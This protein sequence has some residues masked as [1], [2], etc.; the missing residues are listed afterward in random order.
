MVFLVSGSFI[1]GACSKASETGRIDLELSLPLGMWADLQG[2]IGR[3]EVW[4]DEGGLTSP[5]VAPTPIVT[6]VIDG[7]TVTAQVADL[8]GDGKNEIRIAYESNPFINDVR[9]VLPITA[10]RTF[11]AGSFFFRGAIYEKNTGVLL[12]TAKADFNDSGYSIAFVGQQS[13]Y[14]RFE[15]EP[16]LVCPDSLSADGG[17]TTQGPAYAQVQLNLMLPVA[18]DTTI[19]PSVQ[20]TLGPIELSVHGVD[21]GKITGVSNSGNSGWTSGTHSPDGGLFSRLVSN[22]DSDPENEVIFRVLTNPFVTQTE[23]GFAIAGTAA[24]APLSIIAILY[25]NDGGTGVSSTSVS[26]DSLGRPIQFGTADASV[27]IAFTCTSKEV[28]GGTDGGSSSSDAGQ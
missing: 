28:C 3:V 10:N 23:G 8:D 5:F 9:V 22:I 16:M 12:M 20:A 21:G 14:L 2:R 4:M 11:A 26:T 25:A 1:E 27:A 18:P 17:T 24:A 13:I 6:G 7:V 15:C 19:A